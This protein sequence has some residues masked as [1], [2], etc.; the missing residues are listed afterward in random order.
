LLS[1]CILVRHPTFVVN[2][3]CHSARTRII[4]GPSDP[5]AFPPPYPSSF[6]DP[7]IS[8]TAHSCQLSLDHFR[9]TSVDG[10]VRVNDLVKDGEWDGPLHILCWV[11]ENQVELVAECDGRD[12]MGR[13][14][15][16]FLVFMHFRVRRP[17]D[18][19][20]WSGRY[21]RYHQ[22]PVAAD[23][24]EFMTRGRLVDEL[25]VPGPFF[26]DD[27]ISVSS[28][29][30]DSIPVSSPLSSPGLFVQLFYLFLSFLQ[31]NLAAEALPF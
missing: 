13:R 15:V 20:G 1:L 16:R 21:P 30:D 10:T 17:K 24:E 12:F 3:H 27:S 26:I 23:S 4:Y 7:I 14:I 11:A 6:F 31:F 19:I 9:I 2:A 22:Y 18:I 28:P 8:I 5:E 29:V 25:P